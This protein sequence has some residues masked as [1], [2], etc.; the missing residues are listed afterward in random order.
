MNKKNNYGCF[1]SVFFNTADV[2]TKCMK[3]IDFISKLF[4]VICA[5][6]IISPNV[7][8]D[9]GITSG[10]I[11]SYNP[12]PATGAMGDAGI[13][14]QS[15]KA[16][17]A[18]LNPASTISTYRIIAS[19]S[20]SSLFGG[21]QY[22][23][24]GAQFPTV[25]GNFGLSVMYAGYGEID[26]LDYQGH[27]INMADTNDIAFVLNYSVDIKKTIP[28]EVPYG[29]FGINMKVLRSALGDYS[30]EAF[31]VDAG[32][33]YTPPDLENFSFAVVYRN[34]GSS[35]KFVREAYS[36]PQVLTLG[37]AY[38]EKDF[39]DLKVALDYSAQIFSGNYFS[40]GASITPIYFLTFRGGIKLAEESLNSDIRLGLGFEF[41]SIMVDYSYTPSDMSNG[42]HNFNFS[43]AIG[44]FTN[45]KAAY[46]YYMQNHFRSA[47][48]SFYAKDFITAR[49]K[50]DEILSVYPEHR[51]SQK[52]LQKIVDQLAEID[53][54]NARRVRS[55]MKKAE[56][57][58]DKGNAV[59][60]A[61]NYRK[62]LELDP[63]N[64]IAR[65][66]IENVDELTNDVSI[67]RD[68]EKNKNRIEYL[69]KRYEGFYKKGELVRAKESLGFIIDIDPENQSAKEGI[70]SIDNQLSKIASDKIAEMYS[71][72]MNLFNQGKFQESIRF[73]EAVVIAAP[74]RRDAQ[75]LI[76]KAEKNIQDIT[77]YERNKK[78]LAS[79]D[80]V[81]GELNRHFEDGLKHYER[82]RLAEAVRS[83]K[84]AKE[85]ADRYEF[86]DYSKNAQNYIAKISY[87]LSEIHYRRGFEFFRKNNFEAAA[88]EY[89]TA[90]NY[91]P[92]NTSAAFELSRVG[93][94]LAQKFYEDGMTY[95]SRGDFEKAREFLKRSLSFKPDKIEAR[96]ALEK[97]Q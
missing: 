96:R 57:A 9:A 21:I 37:M 59:S 20:N 13:A 53:V 17:A 14:L 4:A 55:Y 41:Q 60:A 73:F 6:M 8:A 95:Y 24:V 94:Q 58:L 72:G 86:T 80:K 44:K 64:T 83:F 47:V 35:M 32:G 16:A 26:Y 51:P 12:N 46:D 63:E 90:L 67:L 18:I 68:R 77:E 56:S 5:L 91:N 85:I 25:V 48:E 75:E 11:L 1:N 10:Q 87:D 28:L 7:F 97:I 89:R 3:K 81:R 78:V 66:G 19:A 31:L 71:Q 61:D 30:T 76:A 79:Q 34:L 38:R 74:H 62:V 70:I 23:Y 50:F 52:Y 36:M 92:A 65:K 29:G 93:E 49:Q 82:N 39:Y 88:A 40:L 54:Y 69:W 22:N 45:Q 2:R 33:I 42:T 15:D 27:S 43:Y 84:K